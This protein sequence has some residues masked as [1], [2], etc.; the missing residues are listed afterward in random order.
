M[1]ED[2]DYGSKSM[3]IILIGIVSLMAGLLMLVT[4]LKALLTIYQEMESLE[5]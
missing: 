2:S 1:G 5:L 4:S 3:T